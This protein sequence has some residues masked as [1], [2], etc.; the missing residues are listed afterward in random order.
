MTTPN[1]LDV[2]VVGAGFAGIY[3]LHA[4]R[5]AG[6]SVVCLEAADGVGGTWHFNRYPGC[7]CDVESVDYSYSFDEKLQEE[8]VWSERYA[9]QPEILSYINHVVD[10]FDLRRDIELNSRVESARFDEPS[11]RW[12]LTTG[13]GREYHARYVLFATGALSTPL[14]PDIPGVADF[15]GEVYY[16][17][18]W[19]DP[20]PGF[21]GKRVGVIGTGSSGIQAVPVIAEEA[22]ALTVFQRTANYSVPAHN[23]AIT[24]EDRE[25]IRQEYPA[26]RVKS[27]MSGGGSPHEAHPK[28]TTEASEQERQAAFEKTWR[29][30]GVLFSKTFPDQLKDLE[31]N[32]YAQR[33]FEA[34]LRE[35]VHD[36]Q[37]LADLTPNDH[38]LGT[39]R[40]CTDSGY[41]ET[42]NR[43][44]VRLV[45]LRRDPIARIT[46]DAVV[47]ESGRHELDA[48]IFAT[49]FDAM[50]GTLNQINPEGLDGARIRDAWADGPETYLGMTIP[51][52]PNM[53]VLNGPGSPAV[54]ANMVLTSE[55]QVDW[56]VRL[57]T[58]ARDRG[59][60]QVEPRVDAAQK[61]GA[62]VD[63]FAR[64]TLFHHADS[65]YVG[66]NVEGK[67]RT[68]M[69]YAAGLGSY[70][71]DC[72]TARTNG[73]EGL[74]LSTR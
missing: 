56:I 2:V 62:R 23:R 59:I 70:T 43:E 50:T 35:K 39:K 68:F 3:A 53:F 67:K 40:I 45:N 22:D 66:A 36:H 73:Y 37:I 18:Q 8:W 32:R 29:N 27:R 65:W 64:H 38:P 28:K 19:P 17:A 6:F 52:F 49:G 55:Q 10:R 26:R 25:R 51:D 72:E 21:T 1:Q 33:F 24:A 4:T 34:K 63:E 30:G 54:L 42:F 74:V 61:W 20:G 7:R 16:T 71:T 31:A 15:A 47:T 11:S 41:Y 48:L 12:L 58:E 46:A 5:E 14:T 60:T 69:L 9:T 44:H 57:L 13:D